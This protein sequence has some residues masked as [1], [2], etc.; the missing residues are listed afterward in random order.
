MEGEESHP[1]FLSFKIFLLSLFVPWPFLTRDF[2]PG[3]NLKYLKQ[4]LVLLIFFLR[5][6][7]RNVVR[8]C[9]PNARGLG[10]FSFLSL[11]VSV[12]VSKYSRSKGR[13]GWKRGRNKREFWFF[14]R[15][16]WTSETDAILAHMS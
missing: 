8:A 15:A 11:C 14:E 4:L 13:R 5:Y 12:C 16:E 6:K 7:M 9:L 10:P 2:V 1:L 3:S